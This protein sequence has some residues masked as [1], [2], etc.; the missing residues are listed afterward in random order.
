MVQDR[1]VNPQTSDQLIYDKGSKN[2]QWRKDRLFNTW[3]WENWTSTYKG[4]KLEH[5]LIPYAI[6]NSK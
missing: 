4:M 1:K 3:S 5:Y 2:I 6:I